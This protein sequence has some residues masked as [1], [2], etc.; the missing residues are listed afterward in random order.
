MDANINGMMAPGSAVKGEGRT[1]L[2]GRGENGRDVRTTGELVTRVIAGDQAAA[3]A[4]VDEVEPIL[5]R[6][7]RARRPRRGGNH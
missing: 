2:Q 1:P 5:R 4:L 7:V 3:R 6:I